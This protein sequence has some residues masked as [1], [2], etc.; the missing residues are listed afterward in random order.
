MIEATQARVQ[1]RG[2]E[3]HQQARR[4]TGKFE[5]G[6][7]L[8]LMDGMQ[9]LYRF[10]FDYDAILHQKVNREP[11]PNALTSVVES[12]VPLDFDL[13]ASGA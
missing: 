9:A 8:G 5:I 13:K 10:Q 11:A 6:N 7:Y 12:H 1:R 4:T 2:V 3:I